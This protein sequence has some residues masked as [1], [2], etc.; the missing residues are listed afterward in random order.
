MKRKLRE[1]DIEVYK[2]YDKKI[3]KALTKPLKSE[4]G[5]IDFFMPKKKKE[6]KKKERELTAIGKELLAPKIWGDPE[7]KKP[8]PQEQATEKVIEK[9]SQ[10]FKPLTP[11]NQ[12]K[13]WCNQMKLW[14]WFLRHYLIPVSFVAGLGF[15]CIT[16]GISHKLIIS[17]RSF[18][19]FVAWHFD[20]VLVGIGSG[21]V[22]FAYLVYK[23]ATKNNDT[24]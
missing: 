7:P 3:S 20:P 15:F 17:R 19:A 22:V 12:T 10:E 21:L 14:N 11:S 16:K 4:R 13:K 8:T 1:K 24:M 6:P 18:K 5:A 9:L 2:N 23:Q